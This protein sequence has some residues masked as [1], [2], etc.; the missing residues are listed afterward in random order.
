LL[1]RPSQSGLQRRTRR[2]ALLDKNASATPQNPATAIQDLDD[3]MSAPELRNFGM[4]LQAETREDGDLA[5][6]L[7]ELRILLPG[8]QMLTAF[9]IILPFNTGAR[10]MIQ[11][12]RLGFL[13]TFFFALASLVL[14]S[15][16]AIQ[17]RM[18]RP[19]Q[20]RERFKRLAT[21]QI[22]VG[23][24]ALALAF[25]L[26]TNLVLSGVFGTL[27]GACASLK[28]RHAY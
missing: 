9:L 18:M 19:L 27:A 22:V 17:H 14:L 21:R 4:P 12:N 6:M 10:V 1:L 23:S 20:C 26:G 8:T 28:R 7:S 25:I 15:A 5:D 11:E 2:P 13:A 3:T 24:F 16:P